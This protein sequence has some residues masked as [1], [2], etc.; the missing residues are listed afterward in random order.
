MFRS[1]ERVDRDHGPDGGLNNARIAVGRRG[2]RAQAVIAG[3]S[4]I[5]IG[6]LKE[7]RRRL[8]LL[9]SEGGVSEGGF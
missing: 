8:R 4:V 2:K 1:E 6:W 9:V 3:T 7:F 5:G